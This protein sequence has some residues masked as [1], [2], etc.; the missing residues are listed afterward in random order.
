MIGLKEDVPRWIIV[1]RRQENPDK[2]EI[3]A[4]DP[5]DVEGYIA[6]TLVAIQDGKFTVNLDALEKLDLELDT[7]VDTPKNC[8]ADPKV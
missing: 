8:S 7:T 5:T 6:Q 3:R 1:M 4:M 2:I